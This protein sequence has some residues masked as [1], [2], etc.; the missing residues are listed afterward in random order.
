MSAGTKA[1]WVVIDKAAPPD[2]LRAICERCGET[3]SNRLPLK[4][5]LMAK[6]VKLFVAL[7]ALC[8]EA[9]TPPGL[10]AGRCDDKRR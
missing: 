7:H 10:P 1:P 3:H 6:R 9:K 5:D 2:I 4:I 8:P